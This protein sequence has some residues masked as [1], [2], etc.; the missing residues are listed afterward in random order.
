MGPCPALRWGTIGSPGQGPRGSHLGGRLAELR[1]QSRVFERL[2]SLV[3]A[4]AEASE[5]RQGVRSRHHRDTG[6]RKKFLGPIC[7]LVLAH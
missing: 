5:Q 4:Q 7:T 2:S 1:A 6:N 3:F